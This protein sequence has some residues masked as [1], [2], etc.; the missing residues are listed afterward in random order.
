MRGVVRYC[1]AVLR[2][3]ALCCAVLRCAALCHLH[4]GVCVVACL[5]VSSNT[6]AV[7]WN[8]CFRRTDGC[9]HH[10]PHTHTTFFVCLLNDW[11]GLV[12]GWVVCE[13][14]LYSCDE[15]CNVCCYASAEQ[16]RPLRMFASGRSPRP[17][18]AP[19]HLQPTQLT[20][21]QQHLTATATAA[22]AKAKQKEAEAEAEAEAD[23][24]AAKPPAH[25]PYYA[26]AVDAT[27]AFVATIGVD[28]TQALVI[29]TQTMRYAGGRGVAWRRTLA[30][31]SYPA[32]CRVVWCGV[33]AC[34]VW[35]GGGGGGGGGGG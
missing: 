2:C 17:A 9:A 24:A 10:T 16:Y 31:C 23:A 5:C 3:A 14:Y 20:R 13:Q 11:V 15:E 21:T 4:T 12:L 18:P 26:L 33:V 29:D 25:H 1:G 19:H 35:C 34:V 30:N 27:G 28:P 8:W 7:W 6:Q 22:T 32:L